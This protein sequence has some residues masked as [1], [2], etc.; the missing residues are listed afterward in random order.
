MKYPA[1]FLRWKVQYLLLLISKVL[2]LIW[3]H[4]PQATILCAIFYYFLLFKVD[5]F[6]NSISVRFP[7][8]HIYQI[9]FTFCS[10]GISIH[11]CKIVTLK[12]HQFVVWPLLHHLQI[13]RY[14]MSKDCDLG[15]KCSN[16]WFAI[17]LSYMFCTVKPGWWSHKYS[18]NDL[19]THIPLLLIF[20]LHQILDFVTI[21]WGP[22]YCVEV[23]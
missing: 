19:L 22:G 10:S 12:F 11:Q 9:K 8:L 2:H 17:F 4:W 21:L 14:R 13:F 20:F 5:T 6:L 16:G 7:R 1:V 18:F 3:K 23:T 15:V